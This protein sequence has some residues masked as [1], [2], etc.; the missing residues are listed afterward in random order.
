MRVVPRCDGGAGKS[1]SGAAVSAGG[2]Q[3]GRK[4]MTGE[5]MPGQQPPAEP[6]LDGRQRA[7]GSRSG[8]RP[9]RHRDRRHRPRSA[10]PLESS[11]R[12]HRPTS[13]DAAH[14]PSARGHTGQASPATA[15][16]CE[17]GTT[18]PATTRDKLLTQGHL[19]LARVWTSSCRKHSERHWTG[20][21]RAMG[22]PQLKDLAAD[23]RSYNSHRAV[24]LSE[25]CQYA[26][27]NVYAKIGTQDCSSAEHRAHS[28]ACCR[29]AA[30]LV[31]N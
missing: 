1:A 29:L 9:G 11:S 27:R 30:P 26:V 23:M 7:R 16:P 31:R 13:A 4:I 20:F 3:L 19:P 5:Y 28:G 8:A 2:R 24:H 25:D 12:Y 6:D 15:C 18:P 17:P 21:K 14:K 22:A 10:A